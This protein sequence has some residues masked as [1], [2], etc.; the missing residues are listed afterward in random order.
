MKVSLSWLKDFVDINISV[1]K[2]S[3]LL[4]LS[5]TKVEA[6]AKVGSDYVLDLEITSNRPDCLGVIGVAREIA[7]VLDKELEIPNP[8]SVTADNIT[9]EF[10]IQQ[11]DPTLTTVYCAVILKDLDIKPI[12]N[13]IKE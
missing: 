10:E 13:K 7:A 9:C 1:D 8:S 4:L 11:S 12:S 5:G 6:V 2:L 3:E